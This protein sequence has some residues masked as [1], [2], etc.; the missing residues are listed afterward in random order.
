METVYYSYYFYWNVSQLIILFTSYSCA[1]VISLCLIFSKT[2]R[3]RFTPIVEH[4][5]SS[6]LKSYTDKDG[7]KAHSISNYKVPENYISG[8]MVIV[9][10]LFQ[11]AFTQFLDKF[12]FEETHG[13]TVDKSLDCFPSNPAI[14]TQRLDCY[15]TS[16][17]MDN[18]ITSVICYRLVLNL[19]LATGSALGTVTT[20][21]LAIYLLT[22]FILK[23]SNRKC[24]RIS[25]RVW[26]TISIKIFLAIAIFIATIL[27]AI[28]QDA[29]NLHATKGI[30]VFMRN[31]IIGY[32]IAYSTLAFPWY[33]FEKIEEDRSEREPLTVNKQ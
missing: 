27:L 28:Y 26:I 12:F 18:N 13:C 14:D 3:Q 19:G 16:Y 11:V 6:M 32:A 23:V 10:N 20:T 30:I 1:V 22:L 33:K 7:K 2:F 24:D 31:A 17:L 4:V 21:A 9:L 8:L 25:C 15:N 29:T 5:F